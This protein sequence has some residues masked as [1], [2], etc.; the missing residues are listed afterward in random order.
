MRYLILL[1]VLLAASGLASASSGEAWNKLQ[2]DTRKACLAKSGFK[3][4]KVVEGPVMFANAVLYRIGG[5]WPQPHMKGKYGKVYYQAAGRGKC[6]VEIGKRIYVVGSSAH[7]PNPGFT[8]IFA[9]NA[10]NW[11][12]VSKDVA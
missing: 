8:T 6:V 12:T 10:I 1:G 9:E 7:L 3:N 2:A 5:N 11:G 4:A